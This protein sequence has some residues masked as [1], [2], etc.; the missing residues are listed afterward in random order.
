MDSNYQPKPTTEILGGPELFIDQGS[1]INLTC[2]VQFAPE[3]PPTVGWTHEKQPI[4]FDSP[5][6][7]ISLVTEKGSTTSSRLLIQKASSSD[8]GYYSCDPSNAN[9]ATIRVH[10]LNGWL[11]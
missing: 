1:T 3:P 9:S 11:P 8:T 7:G 10:I 5:R 2:L 4:N 6:G